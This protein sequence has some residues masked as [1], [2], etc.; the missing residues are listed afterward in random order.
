MIRRNFIKKGIMAAAFPLVPAQGNGM[1]EDD[2]SVPKADNN[3]KLSLNA[4]SFHSLL[5]KG[6]MSLED[7]F[8]YCSQLGFPGVDLTAYYFQGY[9]EV[10]EDRLLYETKNR[11][12]RQGLHISGTGVRNDFTLRDKTERRK[13]VELVKNW[14]LAASKLGAPVIRIFS[15]TQHVEPEAWDEVAMWMVEDVLECVEFG[16][17]HGVIVAMQNHND[18]IKTADQMNY[19]F[20]QIDSPWFGQ[21]LDIGSYS[22][23]DSY[24]EIKKNIG[25]AVSW[26]IKEMVN[27]FGEQKE[28]DLLKLMGIIKNSNYHGYLPIETLGPGDPYEKVKN[29]LV[30]VKA[31]MKTEGLYE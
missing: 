11:A 19:F 22:K 15:G 17:E 10:P 21:I 5:S 12:T 20:R 4:Y 31:A 24:E 6:E 27:H 25:H 30:A 14:I 29:F 3:I 1:H 18:F 28:V 8:R 23:L 13:E 16:K 7:L 9:P 26:Q 2:L